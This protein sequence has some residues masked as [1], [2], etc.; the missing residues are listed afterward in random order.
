MSDPAGWAEAWEEARASLGEG[1]VPIGAALVRTSDGA[2]LARGRN[3]RCQA[4][5]LAYHA[6]IVCLHD[7]GLLKLAELRETTLVST[8]VPCWMCAGAVLQ[9]GIPRVVVGMAA[10]E[11]ERL[12]SHELLVSHGIEVVDLQ[13]PEVLEVMMEHFSEHPVDGLEDLGTAAA[14]VDV[15]AMIAERGAEPQR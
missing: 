1:G 14:G 15:E 9:H 3:R 10:V 12:G 7:A 6:E 4:G 2:V 8:A 13:R 5:G 11:G